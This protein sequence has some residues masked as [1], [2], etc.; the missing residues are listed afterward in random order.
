M[1]EVDLSFSHSYEIEE[2]P[3]LPGTGRI[4]VPVLYFP[5]PKSRPE[6]DG[7]WLRVRTA[8]GESWVGVFAFGYQSPPA[9][10]RVLSS[11]DQNRACIISSGAAYV[12]KTDEPE[13]W[14]QIP[15]VPVLDV[16]LI[17][18]HQLIVFA[19]FTRLAAYGRSG[20]AWRSPR[21]C[22]DGLKILNVTHDTIE[23]IGYDPTNL[24][25]SRFAVDVIMGRSLL[26]SPLSTDG[27]PMWD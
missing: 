13:T 18:E 5:R 16:R 25:E 14:E 4:D 20:L 2:L 17:P 24:G 1:V 12:V 23:G 15:I 21:V 22:W 8:S 27:K 3:E 9:I 10:S 26:P 19:D 11:P 7:L 6:H